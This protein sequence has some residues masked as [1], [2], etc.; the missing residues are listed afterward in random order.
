ME[1]YTVHMSTVRSDIPCKIKSINIIT[2]LGTNVNTVNYGFAVAA[3]RPVANMD[4]RAVEYAMALGDGGNGNLYFKQF[5]LTTGGPP[6][7]AAG[8]TILV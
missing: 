3:Y 5:R 7:S 8:V 6:V 1:I 2:T 4:N